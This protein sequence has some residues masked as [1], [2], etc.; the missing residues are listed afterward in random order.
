MKKTTISLIFALSCLFLFFPSDTFAHELSIQIEEDTASE[1]L[2]VDVIWGHIR[3][4]VDYAEV[5]EFELH[6]RYP[7]GEM[8]ELALEAIGVQGRAYVP[9][10][11]EGDYTFWAVKQP[12]TYTPDGGVT[13]LSSH[14]AKAVYPVGSG[15]DTSGQP[16]ELELEIVPAVSINDFSTGTFSGTVLFT[17]NEAADAT[18]TAYGPEGEV[19]ETVSSSEGTFDFEL[20]TTGEWLIKAHLPEEEAGTLEGEDYEAISRN[21]TLLVD[22]TTEE[23][24]NTTT[25][26]TEGAAAE[27]TENSETQVPSL[28]AMLVVG[29]LVGATATLFVLKKKGSQENRD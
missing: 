24:E 16:V 27:E 20:D 21:T 25:E 6:V 28:V 26:Q 9:A 4:F 29:L 14:M 19:L 13:Q 8:E 5:D 3:D 7:S 23:T 1:E 10:A 22:T 18:V 12:S 17:E 15:S 2:R 11:E